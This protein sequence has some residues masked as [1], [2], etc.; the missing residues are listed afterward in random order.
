M[1]TMKA[2]YALRA[3]GALANSDGERL[4]ARAIAERSGAPEKF[5]EAIL[6]ELR[7]AGLVESRRGQQGGHALSRPAE[8]IRIGDVI[9]AIDGPL[10]PVRCA[11][12]TA[13]RAC[14]ECPEP[15]ACALRALMRD[16]RDA[17]AGVLD[18]RSLRDFAGVDAPR[19]GASA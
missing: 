2:K 5:L 9:R 15:D 12:V 17:L 3:L 18:G 4:Q 14:A 13:Y 7:D 19:A 16:A 11:S 8:A 10:A 6:V 1:L